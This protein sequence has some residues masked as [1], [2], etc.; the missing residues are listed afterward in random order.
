MKDVYH[1]P[2]FSTPLA[3]GGTKTVATVHDVVF[4]RRPEL[5]ESKLRRYLDR[6]TSASCEYANAVITVSDFSR[7]EIRELYGRDPQ[8][9]PNAVG[10]DFLELDDREL[11][12]SRLK[13]TD[14]KNCCAKSQN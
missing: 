5:V 1:N 13:V 10:E 3:P 8:V 7:R 4:K 9:I 12:A 14:E 11:R 2:C 6:W